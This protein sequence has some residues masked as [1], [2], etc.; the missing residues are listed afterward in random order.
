MSN[1]GVEPLIG[2]KAIAAHF[3]RDQRTVMRWAATRGLP[4]KR[5]PGTGRPTIFAEAAA[6]DAWLTTSLDAAA[7]AAAS[8]ALSARDAGRSLLWRLVVAIG[9]A[10]FVLV[11]VGW[12]LWPDRRMP[13]APVVALPADP[14]ARSAYLQATYDWNQ[15]TADSLAR[16]VTEFGTAIAHD[17]VFAPSFAGLASTY[18]LIREFGALPDAQAYP[19][20]EAAAEAAIAIDPDD[21]AAHRALGFVAFWW[22]A[23][24]RRARAE[25]AEAIRLNPRDA[26]THHWLATALSANGEPI[27]ALR[28]MTIAR[29]LD[30]T[31]TAALVDHLL[32]RYLALHDPQDVQALRALRSGPSDIA[33][34]HHALA[35]IALPEGRRDEYLAEATKAATLRGDV[36]GRKPIAVLQAALR[37]GGAAAFDAALIATARAS[38]AP[39]RDYQLARALAVTGN[40]AAALD[41]L[42]RVCR[43]H[44]IGEGM[45]SG[46]PWLARSIPTATTRTLCGA[47]SLLA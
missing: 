2:W 32:L 5:V 30:P 13:E 38:S 43:E 11:L 36:S 17:P 31:S 47:G 46:D 34:V 23:D 39:D 28:E 14:A 29:S 26:L 41:V 4:V 42:T 16:A 24:R 44:R 19:K 21:P 12:K 35:T 10:L 22:H 33:S 1:P 3:R 20:A 27:A 9:I 45:A 40:R 37:G 15:R 25:F 8:N 18:L 7:L 6:L